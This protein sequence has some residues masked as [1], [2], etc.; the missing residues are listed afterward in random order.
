MEEHF[1]DIWTRLKSEI[2]PGSGNSEIVSEG[3]VTLD[4]ILLNAAQNPDVSKN[5]ETKILSNIIPYVSNTNHHL[6]APAFRIADCCVNNNTAF[7]GEKIL[8]AVAVRLREEGMSTDAKIKL[9]AKAQNILEICASKE[10]FTGMDPTTLGEIQKDLL[11]SLR[12]SDPD[13]I[14]L[15]WLNIEHSIGI[16]S[17][18]QRDELYS[19][20]VDALANSSNRVDL[21]RVL[22]KYA[23]A[24]SDE[25]NTKVVNEICNNFPKLS[26]N[27]KR[28]V[29]L[30]FVVLIQIPKFSDQIL[31]LLTKQIFE[32]ENRKEV[33]VALSALQKLLESNL[34]SALVSK[35]WNNYNMLA[36]FRELIQSGSLDKDVLTQISVVISL[37]V[38]QLSVEE[39]QA[40]VDKCLPLIQLNNPSDL[41]IMHGILSHVDQK[42][43]IGSHFSALV[44]KLV[45]MCL[46]IED[47]TVRRVGN[48][49]VCT[50]VNRIERTEENSAAVKQII[51][52]LRE[53][54]KKE[55]K[56]AVETLS[57]V[58]KGLIVGGFEEAGDIIEDVST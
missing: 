17:E 18:I 33:G 16:F 40:V 48:T 39:Q 8:G 38:R 9:I 56:S 28:N 22:S 21:S 53:E 46:E 34:E 24:F 2:L 52:T 44:T 42:V 54:I 14:S 32:I 10:A 30:N 11:N 1:D 43:S 15:A 31:N 36:N 7:A 20:L 19:R 55:K 41:F 58:A 37:F 49:L 51:K 45:H 23:T 12:T 29:Y 57:W 13:L 26:E 3:F 35:I 25:V 4:A 47:E 6:F 5:V 50:L 27:S